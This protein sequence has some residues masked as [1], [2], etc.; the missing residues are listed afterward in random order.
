MVFFL[1]IYFFLLCLLRQVLFLLSSLTL[2]VQMYLTW[3]SYSYS[4][5]K[6]LKEFSAFQSDLNCKWIK[7]NQRL[8]DLFLWV[9]NSHTYECHIQISLQTTPFSI[10][11]YFH[12]D[13]WPRFLKTFTLISNRDALYLS[14][15]LGRA[16]P[17]A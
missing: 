1:W 13:F 14:G 10:I 16:F 7:N 5:G 17:W 11:E 4:T 3:L 9:S 6:I 15:R 12:P 2:Q 8:F